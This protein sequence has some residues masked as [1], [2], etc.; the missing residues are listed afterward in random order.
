M[1]R[2]VENQ[3]E[4]QARWLGMFKRLER[5]RPPC[6]LSPRELAG[7]YA[8]A[9][10]CYHGNAHSPVSDGRFDE[11]CRWLLANIEE[12]RR[13][14][15]DMLD[16][17]MLACDSGYDLTRFVHPYHD[18]ASMLLESP[19]RCHVCDEWQRP[20]SNSTRDAG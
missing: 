3:A 16:P 12:C 14:G 10:I 5:H 9:S 4:V 7:L 2:I 15:A 13:E 17:E 19:C 11:L 8:V 20:Q 18:I 1:A 6:G